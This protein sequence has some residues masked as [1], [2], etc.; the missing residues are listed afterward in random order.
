MST[1]FTE[2]SILE[3]CSLALFWRKVQYPPAAAVTDLATAGCV[4]LIFTWLVLFPR[5]PDNL[6]EIRIRNDRP[7]DSAPD[8]PREYGPWTTL[9]S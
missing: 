3:R 5:S 8:W 1:G 7:K 2:V 9:D 4:L 6:P